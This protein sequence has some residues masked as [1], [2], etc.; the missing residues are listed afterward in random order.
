M[1]NLI[2]TFTQLALFALCTIAAEAQDCAS[3]TLVGSAVSNTTVLSQVNIVNCRG[4]ASSGFVEASVNTATSNNAVARPV[5]L[6]TKLIASDGTTSVQISAQTVTVCTPVTLTFTIRFK[7]KKIDGT[8]GPEQV[9]TVTKT[10]LVCPFRLDPQVLGVAVVPAE[11]G[12]DSQVRVTLVNQGAQTPQLSGG[13]S[14]KVN[15]TI[16]ED[17]TGLVRN[18]CTSDSPS[19]VSFPQLTPGEQKILNLNF[20]FPQPG[21]FNLKAEVSLFEPEDG[22]TNNNSQTKSVTVP[23]P[24]PLICEV[25][26]ATVNPGDPVKMSGNWFQTFGTKEIPT[27]KFGTVAAQVVNVAS[28]L[29]MTV[30]MP[31]LTCTASGQVPVTVSNSAGAAVFQGGPTFPGRLTITGTSRDTSPPGADEN[32]TINLTNFRPRCT[33]TVTFEPGPSTPGGALP[34][35]VVSTTANSIVVRIRPP[36]SG[37]AY[38]LKVQTPYGIATKSITVGEL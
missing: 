17:T 34:S 37:A 8:I 33:F 1:K 12:K 11:A 4:D 9:K 27:V 20:K 14:Y 28:P 21:S 16:V 26:P 32:L 5:P 35:T 7:V 18:S 19:L 24:K 6:N 23:L 2:K 31:D 36:I 15:L 29:N 38:T 22:P 3:V 13:G 25:A 30:R 10:L